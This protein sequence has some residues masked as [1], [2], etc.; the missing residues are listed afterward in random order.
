MNSDTGASRVGRRLAVASAVVFALVAVA[1]GVGLTRVPSRAVV[2]AAGRQILAV[3]AESQYA[4]VLRQIGGAQVA[5][6]ALMTNPNADPHTFEAS[7]AVA[8]AIASARIVVQN[9]LGYDSFMNKIEA[10]TP[11]KQRVVI[12]AQQLRGLPDNTLNPHLW[13]SPATM[14][15]VAR[16]VAEDLTSIDPGH[17]ALFAA[18]LIVFIASLRPWTTL[19]GEVAA[20]AKGISVA[21]T[22]PVADALLAAAKVHNATPWAFQA[23][24]MNGVDPAPQIVGL[25]EQL[26]SSQTTKVF[27]Y[28]AQVTDTLTTSLLQIASNDHVPVVAVYE[29]MPRNYHYQGWM[30]AETDAL[31]A[32]IEHGTSTRALS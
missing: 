30:L 25:V 28:N 12:S 21:T 14:P 8:S 11:S 18:N 23:D 13:Y 7:P 29:T 5:V 24:V 2:S 3:A 9:G 22:E 32:A 10:A 17:K 4:D 27:L 6:S 31:L 1:V 16:A 15:L 19:L 26:L 20:H